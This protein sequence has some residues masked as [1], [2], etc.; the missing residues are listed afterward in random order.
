MIRTDQVPFLHLYF[1]KFLFLW[2]LFL[3]PNFS[4]LCPL[5]CFSTLALRLWGNT[6]LWL[7]SISLVLLLWMYHWLYLPHHI[8]VD[9]RTLCSLFFKP[10]LCCGELNQTT[11]SPGKWSAFISLMLS[12]P[13][14]LIALNTPTAL[15]L[16]MS[17]E[18]SICLPRHFPH[19][20]VCLSLLAIFVHAGLPDKYD[21][22]HCPRS[23]PHNWSGD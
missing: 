21:F 13:E 4:L 18:N 8:A 1:F 11:A 9:S 17:N 14:G 22:S 23:R 7:L 20:I 2:T 3:S 5:L 15:R 12:Q 10:Y 6:E 19:P 16:R